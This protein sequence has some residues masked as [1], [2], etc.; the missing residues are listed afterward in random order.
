MS[1]AFFNSVRSSLFGGRLTQPQVDGMNAIFQAW[2]FYGDGDRRKLAYILSTA[3]HET[4]RTMEPVRE[5]LA[6]TDAKAKELLT[7]AWRAGKMP[8][9]KTDYWSGG[10]FGRGFVQITHKANY[11][12]VQDETGH[13]LVANPSL[14]LDPEIAAMILVKGMMQGWFTGRKLSDFTDFAAMRRVVNGT[15]RAAIIA[16]YAEKFLA[17]LPVSAVPSPPPEPAPPASPG[18]QPG[19]VPHPPPEPQTST[20]QPHS[21]WSIIAA[22]LMRI[23]GKA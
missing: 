18:A 20:P 22:F 19:S 1:E 23:F 16:G 9:V 12:K 14:A 13:P 5:T 15:D 3:Y 2:N 21:L 7:K 10:Y 6:K 17:A 4:A 8:Q 11:Q